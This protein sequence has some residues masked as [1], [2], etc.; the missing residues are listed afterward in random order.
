[1]NIGNN[2]LISGPELLCVLATPDPCT[3][4]YPSNSCTPYDRHTCG[5]YSVLQGKWWEVPF[6]GVCMGPQDFL[7]WP[8]E[9]VQVSYIYF[10]IW[11]YEDVYT[12]CDNNGFI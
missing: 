10:Y 1:M 2:G 3:C 11:P 6:K 4:V 12:V 5:L 7:W 9:H 8:G